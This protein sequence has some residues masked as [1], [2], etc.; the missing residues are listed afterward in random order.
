[1]K[2]ILLTALS[3]IVVAAL[4]VGLT[5]AYLQH[6]DEDVNVMTMGN[7]KIK[8]HEYQRATDENGNYK[9]ATFDEVTSYVLEGFEQGKP[10][11]PAIIPNGGRLTELRGI[12][13][14]HL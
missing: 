10:L 7:V 8:Q 12:T 4:A 2:R 14:R 5:V 13:T 6:S 3:M 9:T 1:M 11:Y